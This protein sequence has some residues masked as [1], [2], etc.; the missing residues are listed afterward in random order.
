[1][2]FDRLATRR[3]LLGDLGAEGAT[4]EE[5]LHYGESPFQEPTREPPVL[6]LPAEP[7]LEDWRR[8]QTEAG[9]RPFAYLR[10]RLPQLRV[11]IAAG[12]SKSDGYARVVKRGEPFENG[13]FQ[14]ELRLRR[15][16]GLELRIHDHAAGPLPV[17]ET[18]DRDD[19]ENLV[20]ALA[21]RSEPVAV[22]PSVNAQI[23]AGLA[24]W[25]RLGRYR[26][27]WSRGREPLAA[28][29]AWPDELRRVAAKEPWRFQDRLLLTCRAPYSSV[30]ATELGVPQDAPS[31]LAAS[32]TLRIEHEFTHYTTKRVFGMMSLN[33]LDETLADF[34]GMTRALGAY[35][36]AW[37]LRFLGL[38][39]WPEVREDGRIH[40]YTAGLSAAAA[41][42]AAAVTVRA[43]EALQALAARHYQERERSRF[44]LAL[45]RLPLDLLASNAAEQA[46]LDSYAEARGLL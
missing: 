22:G 23:V 27:E 25:E 4:L 36:S 20:R 45:A 28:F 14:E 26:A 31:W 2:S 19:F 9:A 8:Y 38:D 35:R 44:L 41:A 12:V 34:M 43:A 18:E 13:G 30:S 5:L 39:R 24:N 46:F 6:P 32:S 33:L 21:F 40:T 42:I 16:E 7:H 17:L 29:Q 15:P 10:E 3:E 1:M 11:P 37:F